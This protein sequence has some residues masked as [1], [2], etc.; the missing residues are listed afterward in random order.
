MHFEMAVNG[1]CDPR[2]AGAEAGGV[3]ELTQ[4]Y[5][6]GLEAFIRRCPQ[7]YWWLHRRWKDTRVQ[8]TARQKAA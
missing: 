5:T 7:Q 8:R 4:W 3:R 2:S 6:A 1:V